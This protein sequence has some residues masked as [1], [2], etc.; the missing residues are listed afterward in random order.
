MLQHKSI[1]NIISIIILNLLFA[2]TTAGRRLLPKEV[3]PQHS[4]E[5]VVNAAD[6][7]PVYTCRYCSAQKYLQRMFKNHI[8]Y[9]H[10]ITSEEYMQ[11]M[12]DRVG[13]GGV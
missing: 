12:P 4:I 7:S 1:D 6:G 11:G 9:K 8:L 10:K 5:G 2:P 3:E 13:W